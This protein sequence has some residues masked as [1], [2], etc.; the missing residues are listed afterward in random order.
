MSLDLSNTKISSAALDALVDRPLNKLSVAGTNVSADELIGFIDRRTRNLGFKARLSELDVSD[1]N[2]T[3]GDLSRVLSS[4][5]LGEAIAIRGYGLTDQQFI[6][7]LSAPRT[8]N[9]FSHVDARN[10]NLTGSFMGDLTT[11]NY[12]N[13]LRLDEN[14]ISDQALKAVVAK[15]IGFKAYQLSFSKTKL[16]D[17]GL[18]TMPSLFFA[19]ELWL[20]EGDYTEDGLHST[21]PHRSKI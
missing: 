6:D 16:T 13:R 2:W 1:M 18:L 14:P 4:D 21:V 8:A 20:G 15:N 3:V 9:Q 19:G 10:N 11:P 5:L 12:L 17:A 7:L